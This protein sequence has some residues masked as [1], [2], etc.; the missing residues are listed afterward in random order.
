VDHVRQDLR[1]AFRQ[2]GRNPAFAAL[3]VLTLALGIGAN[4]AIFSV[5]NGVVLK[6][7]PYPDADRV[8][9]LG[10]D[11]GGGPQGALTAY[12]FEYWREHASVF[13]GVATMNTALVELEADGGG[14]PI[15]AQGLRVSE[16]FL[17][18]L[19]FPP[20]LG[21]DFLPIEDAP[22][23]PLVAILGDRTWR[24]QFDAD[25][26]VVGRTVRIDGTAR[27][28]VGVLPPDFRYV[29][30]PA[31]DGFLLPLQLRADPRD[32]GHNYNALA[33][34]APGVGPDRMRADMDAVFERFVREHPEQITGENERGVGFVSYQDLYV[35]DLQRTLWVLLGAVALVL[36]IA[37]ANVANLLLAR[38]T[39]RRREMAT[40]AALG[41]GRGRLVS[42]IV[43]EGLVIAVIA[44]AVG[45][46]IGSWTVNALL[47]FLP[48]GL[49]RM[50]EIGLDARVLGFT[51]GAAVATG[52]AFG[53]AAAIP[54][55]RTG[56]ATSLK[57]GL[58]GGGSRGGLR[59]RGL[60]VTGEVA[61]SLVLLAGAGL[62]ASSFLQ[63]RSVEPGFN[64]EGLVTASLGRAPEGY[65]E[66]ERVADLTRQLAE[67]LG[68]TPGVSGVAAAT[69]LPLQTGWNIPIAIEGRPDDGEPAIEWRAAS[70]G[71]FETLEIPILRG[72]GFTEQERAGSAPVAII[73]E[74]TARHYWP[75]EDP[76]GRRVLIAN[77][78]GEPIFPG[79]P[80]P[81]REIVGVV[82]DIREIGLHQPPLR[83]VYVPQA[84]AQPAMYSGLPQVII[85]TRRP[86]EAMQALHA[87][88]P[89]IDPRLRDPTFSTMDD[90]VAASIA[91]DRF[92]TLLVGSFAALALLLT[93]VG[94]FGVVSY[95]VRQ[96]THEIGIRMALG[97]GGAQVRRMIVG[98]GM[99]AVVAGLVLGLA[100]SFVLTRFMS[101]MLFGVEP[102][103]PLTFTGVSFLMAG[104]AFAASWLPARRATG[105]DPAT[106]LRTE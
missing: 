14:G 54:A 48:Q 26:E 6:P 20:A 50:D 53:L 104:V 74:A 78:Q 17:R 7:L 90:R 30:S 101:G 69:N 5:V 76:I 80:D 37:C 62:L 83:T 44:G 66:G 86:A 25:P 31:F 59:A 40:R 29:P 23:G 57:D 93:A 45:L 46:L 103:D 41:A 27:T 4:S 105:V 70:P 67:R 92:N 32:G 91:Q 28:V 42:Q 97:A 8:T 22:G 38:A 49:P 96:R 34:L 52:L 82:G 81:V 51:F 35:G 13:E 73:N 95:T 106:A 99:R 68:G 89:E 47:A 75:D 94:I 85:R 2:L 102:G 12:K 72:R 18:V 61:L 19:G 63:L 64:P 60:L 79:E 9:Y 15:D 11:W 55:S 39:T 36:L 16:D 3:A 87:A 43:T 98:Q 10:W 24:E 77:W 21:R 33:R 84:Q 58:P 100:G 1:Y 65:E 56:L 71:Y 88:L